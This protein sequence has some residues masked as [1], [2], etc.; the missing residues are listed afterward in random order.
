MEDVPSVEYRCEWIY[1]Y[2]EEVGI[3]SK[4]QFISSLGFL[5]YDI[6]DRQLS[7]LHVDTTCKMGFPMVDF[8]GV[9]G[10]SSG[11]M[12]AFMHCF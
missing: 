5:V 6:S 9:T 4:E 8:G 11:S 3:V 2:S 10:S 1:E 7:I 12:V